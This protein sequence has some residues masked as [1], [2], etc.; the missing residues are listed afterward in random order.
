MRSRNCAANSIRCARNCHDARPR[1]PRT[2][3][4]ACRRVARTLGRDA[5]RR[6]GCRDSRRRPSRGRQRS[7]GQC[8][9]HRGKRRRSAPR[10]W[11]PPP[12]PPPV[13]IALGILQTVPQEPSVTTHSASDMP[14]SAITPVP[15]LREKLALDERKD[16]PGAEGQSTA[17]RAGSS[18]VP[19]PAAP[20]V[21]PAAPPASAPAKPAGKVIAQSNTDSLAATAPSPDSTAPAAAPQPFPA[22]QKREADESGGQRSRVINGRAPPAKHPNFSAGRKTPQPKCSERPRSQPLATCTQPK[23]AASDDS[24]SATKSRSPRRF[25]RGPDGK[26]ASAEPDL[27]GSSAVREA[28]KPIDVDAWMCASAN[29]TTTASSRTQRRACRDARGRDADRHRRNF[30]HGR[31]SS[32]EH[33]A[34][35]ITCRQFHC[36]RAPTPRPEVLRPGCV[37]CIYVI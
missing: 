24:A 23:A 17:Q 4:G 26:K 1:Q 37:Q 25:R 7:A 10:R 21:R 28:A 12:P 3:P 9:A 33:R 14:A 6:I 2:R 15:P 34:H 19:P 16:A 8:A 5:T 20:T 31:R 32:R 30:A 13:A 27:A 36:R 18:D 29:C 22:E 35:P 11:M